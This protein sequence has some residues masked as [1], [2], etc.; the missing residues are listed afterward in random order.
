MLVK[1]MRMACDE[2]RKRAVVRLE[3]QS[4]LLTSSILEYWQAQ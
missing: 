2:R 1:D 3:G 4:L